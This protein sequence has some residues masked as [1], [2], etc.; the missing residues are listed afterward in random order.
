MRIVPGASPVC[1]ATSLMLSPSA[2]GGSAIVT[3]TDD[4]TAR[5]HP[6]HAG[7]RRQDM[8]RVLVTGATGYVG[9]HLTPALLQR[10]FDVR[11]LVR[12]PRRAALPAGVEVVQGDVL[13]PAT[14]APALDGI[15]VAYYLVHSMGG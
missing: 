11:C 6:E 7:T 13:S 9:G 3:G 2:I 10:G 1:S 5:A 14:L 12:D 8:T 4:A 15:D